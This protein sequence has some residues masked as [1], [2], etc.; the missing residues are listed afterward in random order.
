MVSNAELLCEAEILIEVDTR[1]ITSL[2]SSPTLHCFV[3]SVSRYVMI[4][5][6][7]PSPNPSPEQMLVNSIPVTFKTKKFVHTKYALQ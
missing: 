7:I 4:A 5:K 2:G 1:T 6:L 3:R